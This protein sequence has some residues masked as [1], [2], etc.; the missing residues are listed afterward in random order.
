MGDATRDD[1]TCVHCG[2]ALRAS[3]PFCAA[4]G[5]PVTGRSTPVTT[6]TAPAIPAPDAASPSPGLVGVPRGVRCTAW[7]LDLAV[8]A[9]PALPLAATAAVFHVAEVAYVV[10]PTAFFAGWIWM[11]IWQA[12]AGMSFGKAMLGLRAIRLTDQRPAPFSASLV[13]GLLFTGTAGLAALP[14]L[15]SSG[16]C[17]GWHD[18]IS[19]VTLIDIS[20]GDN[21]LGPRQHTALRRQIDRGLRVVQSPIPVPT[22]YPP[23]PGYRTA[24]GLT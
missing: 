12:L 7:A 1:A 6:T 21:P 11:A 3:A 8:L 20:L 10:T 22:T 5:Q 23:T 19:G 14:V 24:V 15:S 18:R 17:D 4:C 16:P 9:S 13:R 2:S